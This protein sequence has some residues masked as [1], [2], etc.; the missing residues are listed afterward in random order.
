[1][2]SIQADRLNPNNV[3]VTFSNYGVISIFYSNNG[4]TTWTA[5]A[6]NLEEFPDGSGNGPSVAW[7]HIYNNGAISKYYAGTSVGLYSTDS[8]NGLNTIW[9]QEGPNTIGNVVVDM[10][11][12]RIYDSLI[13]VATHGNGIYTNQV[14][15][16]T[17]VNEIQSMALKLNCY[18]N[19]FNSS[20]TIEA[21]GNTSGQ[22]EADIYDISGRCIKKIKQSN[23]TQ[24]VWDGNSY[25]NNYSAAGTYIIH[26][27]LKEKTGFIKV[28]K[29]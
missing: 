8:L 10:I 9:T 18:P 21:S 29:M 6:G 22:M 11:T 27:T 5:V 23:T 28:V 26:V 2:S 16:P 1:M 4:G 17:G 25:D 14:F 12:S 19:P 20:I 13:V 24:L 15:I 7:G 3:L